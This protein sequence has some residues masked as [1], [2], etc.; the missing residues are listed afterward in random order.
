MNGP[1]RLFAFGFGIAYCVLANF[2][3]YLA[4]SHHVYRA[5]TLLFEYAALHNAI[6]WLLALV[7]L[8]SLYFGRYPAKMTAWTVGSVFAVLSLVSLFARGWSGD[9]LGHG[10]ALPWGYVGA[11]ILTAVSGLVV[12]YSSDARPGMTR[13]ALS[14]AR[15]KGRAA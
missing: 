3:V 14:K 1:A 2:E 4:L 13:K 7:L 11:N 15:G 9:I 5:G 6:H 10:H 12:G 8:S